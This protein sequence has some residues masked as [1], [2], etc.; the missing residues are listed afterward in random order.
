MIARR[1]LPLAALFVT[2]TATGCGGS[3]AGEGGPSPPPAADPSAEQ[4][5]PSPPSLPSSPE[6]VARAYVDAINAHDGETVCGLMLES[7][8]YQFRIPGWGECPKFVS[9]YIGYGEESDTDTFYRAAIVSLADG[10]RKGELRSLLLS[11]DVELNE[12]GNEA[13]RRT[14]I[15]D[16]VLWLVE[17]DGRW[18]LAKASGLL[19]VAFAAYQ[20]PDDLLE[21]PDLAA[22]ERKYEQATA[23]EH[24]RQEVGLRDPKDRVFGCDGETTS[25]EDAN[26]DLYVQGG[27]E[28]TKRDARHYATADLRRVDV[29]TEG[30][31]LCVR[32]ALAGDDVKERLV[33]QFGIYSPTKMNSLGAQ[34]ELNV[35]VRPDG[36]AR[37]VYEDRSEED[38][39][40]LHPL[41]PIPGRLG[42]EGDTFSFRVA[43]SDLLELMGDGAGDL[44]EWDG[45]LWGGMTFYLAE[46][47]G[48]RQA[49]S[50]NIHNR[51]A[52]ISHPG[53]KVFESGERQE[54]DLPTG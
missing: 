18:R 31:D 25:Y 28:L 7:A 50:D 13:N 54:R 53:G 44:P 26:S 19:Y 23:A 47:G 37:L 36:R 40:G 14:V 39:H 12:Q 43:R 52:I 20:A 32:V 16:D 17:R 4:A 46:I 45:F 35:D 8:A 22:Q 33:I 9:G 21:A 48:N 42:R 6:D 1:L 15:Y 41:I 11:V 3:P 29:T 10:E 34:L 27:T 30:E 5:A 24:D 51:F 49:I 38:E 2:L